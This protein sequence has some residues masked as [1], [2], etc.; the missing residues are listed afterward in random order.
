MTV[1]LHSEDDWNWCVV[2]SQSHDYTNSLH[3]IHF[4]T[5]KNGSTSCSISRKLPFGD[6]LLC[7]SDAEHSVDFSWLFYSRFDGH[8]WQ[9]NSPLPVT[10][11]EV[12]KNV[13]FLISIEED[14]LSSDWIL[15]Y[16]SSF[17]FKD[18]ASDVL[19][20]RIITRHQLMISPDNRYKQFDNFIIDIVWFH[21]SRSSHF[22]TLD[23]MIGVFWSPIQ[24]RWFQRVVSSCF[25]RIQVITSSMRYFSCVFRT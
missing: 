4:A 25:L 9:L 17:S 14:Q 10:V 24:Q 12:G 3:S 21:L 5:N 2:H 6:S 23:S 18:V 20:P 1:A 11:T 8:D 15:L 22:R 19:A 16:S 7:Y 13:D